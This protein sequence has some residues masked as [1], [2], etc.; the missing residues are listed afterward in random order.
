M[1]YTLKNKTGLN[2]VDKAIA[3]IYRILNSIS[4]GTGASGSWSSVTPA[5]YPITV[6]G[7]FYVT[8]K[9]GNGFTL[10][11]GTLVKVSTVE[12]GAF[13]IAEEED[14]NIAGVIYDR[15]APGKIAKVVI[16]GAVDV[17]FNASGAT[18]GHYFH[19]SKISDTAGTAQSASIDRIDMLRILG[20]VWESRSGSGLARCILKR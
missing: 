17:M 3:E 5:V 2:T 1:I 19:M 20:W 13:I 6:E 9:N 10:P 15:V 12:D 18:K 8:G 4:G 14:Y 7:G 16:F 11:K